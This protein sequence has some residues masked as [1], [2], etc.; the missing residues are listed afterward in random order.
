M[1]ELPETVR[2]RM[3]EMIRG[4]HVGNVF[5]LLHMGDMPDEWRWRFMSYIL[6][7]REG[8]PP[9]TYARVTAFDNFVMHTGRSWTAAAMQEEFPDVE[10]VLGYYK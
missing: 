2:E 4:L 7:L 5:C 10:I 3:V 6:G 8:F 9:G 1:P